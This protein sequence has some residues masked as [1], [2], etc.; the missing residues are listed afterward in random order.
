MGLYGQLYY[1]RFIDILFIFRP[2]LDVHGGLAFMFCQGT[3][4]EGERPSTV[5]LLIRVACFVKKKIML[6]FSKAADLN[7]FVQGVQLY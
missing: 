7:K 2:Q 6:T 1:C 3:L 5:N 4:N